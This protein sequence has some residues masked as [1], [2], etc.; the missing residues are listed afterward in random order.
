MILQLS[1]ELKQ[2]VLR[3]NCW[4]LVN[5]REILR[6]QGLEEAIGHISRKSSIHDVVE[7]FQKEKWVGFNINSRQQ[8]MIIPN[9]R[10]GSLSFYSMKV[11]LPV[12]IS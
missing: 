12:D 2:K 11:T 10:S 7:E 4:G 5:V 8:V 1:N 6:L 3:W 9:H